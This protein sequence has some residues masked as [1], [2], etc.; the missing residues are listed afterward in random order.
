MAQVLPP[1]SFSLPKTDEELF[2]SPLRQSMTDDDLNTRRQPSPEAAR[3]GVT[4]ARG[5]SHRRSSSEPASATD[6]VR[7]QLG[8]A[9]AIGVVCETK[10]HRGGRHLLVKSSVD[11]FNNTDEPLLLTMPLHPSAPS[12]TP[13][14][15]SVHVAPGESKPLPLK[16]TGRG[17]DTAC[18]EIL[19]RPAE[20]YHWG[21]LMPNGQAS[22]LSCPSAPPTAFAADGEGGGSRS[23]A[24]PWMDD[25][26]APLGPKPQPLWVARGWRAPVSTFSRLPR[27]TN[28]AS[29][30]HVLMHKRRYA[31]L[32]SI[33]PKPTAPAHLS[34][35]SG[36]SERV[37][38]RHGGER[39]DPGGQVDER[40]V[41]RRRREGGHSRSLLIVLLL[42]VLLT[43]RPP[44]PSASKP[45][46]P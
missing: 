34:H 32:T 2:G 13:P 14:A 42:V 33:H 41:C 5:R 15:P 38:E 18:R 10:L 39:Q 3:S 12:H 36:S 1:P 6:M 25:G 44:S 30:P 24:G 4:R 43:C 16:F 46:Y 45:G 26:A 17:S 9:K 35:P 11:V 19:I 7:A 28:P 29:Q 22:L 21:R 8:G 23:S 40:Q 27:V 37:N 20:G 31:A